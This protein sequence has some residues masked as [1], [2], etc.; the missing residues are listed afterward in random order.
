MKILVTGATGFVGS[1]LT[2]RL[3]GDGHDVHLLVRRDS[4]RWRIADLASFFTACEVDLRDAAAVETAVAAI[5]PRVIFH[6]ATYG[7]F[8]FQKEEAAIIDSNFIGTVN[9]LNACAKAGFDSFVN[10]GSSSEY[11]VKG[12]PMTE[13][14]PPEPVGAYGV[15]KAAA[16]LYCRSLAVERDL[17]VTTVRL[18]SPY[19]PWDDPRRLIPSVIVSLLRGGAPQLASP[20]S[21]RDFVFV[22][23]IVDIYLK[24]AAHPLI[25]EIINAGSG[26]QHCIGE[27]VATIAE[28]IGSGPAPC[29]GVTESRRPEPKVWVA[30]VARAREKLNW[31]PETSLQEGLTKTVAWFETHLGLYP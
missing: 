20:D 30:D 25:G 1:C 3:I 7:G 18:F 4:N 21:V 10:T 27:V 5:A 8:A 19:G 11:G 31:V 15:S 16:T 24:L 28:L 2:R 29:W 9:L 26:R 17:P 12:K 23:D 14:D 22:D 13:Q 6:L